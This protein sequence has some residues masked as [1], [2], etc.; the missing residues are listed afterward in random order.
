M[1]GTV[2]DFTSERAPCGRTVSGERSIEDDWEGLLIELAYYACG[3][4]KTRQVFHDGSI[5][6]QV[7]RHDG[8]VLADE[9]S[10]AH[11]G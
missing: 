6:M 5:D 9:H 2:I 7:L 1:V 4:R 11:E 8:R 10:A 3:C